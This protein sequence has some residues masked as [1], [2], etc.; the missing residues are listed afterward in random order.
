MCSRTLRISVPGTGQGGTQ[1]QMINWAGPSEGSG[2]CEG[3]TGLTGVAGAMAG[4]M[5][6]GC[7][8]GRLT[9]AGADSSAKR[10]AELGKNEFSMGGDGSMEKSRLDRLGFQNRKIDLQKTTL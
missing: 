2:P 3:L 8:T 6:K 1:S 7:K 9:R 10:V 4:P 5:C